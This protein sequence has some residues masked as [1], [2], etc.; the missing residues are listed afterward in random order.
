MCK[1]WLTLPRVIIPGPFFSVN[2][3][4]LPKVDA[5]PWPSKGVPKLSTILPNNLDPTGIFNLLYDL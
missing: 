5:F 1:G 2:D 3:F 4:M